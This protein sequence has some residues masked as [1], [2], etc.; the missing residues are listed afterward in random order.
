[1][2][3]YCFSDTHCRHIGLNIPDVDVAIFAGDESD[4]SDPIRN[5]VETLNFFE[6]YK[7][8]DIPIKIYVP[9]NHSIAHSKGLV[10]NDQI[11]D[12]GIIPLVHEAAEIEGIKVFGSPYTPAFNP[13]V[14][15]YNV[16]RNKLD[17]YWSQI[18]DEAEL[19]ITHGPGKGF[20][21]LTDCMETNKII[22]VG[23][24]SLSNRMS[25]LKSLKLHVSGH[26]HDNSSRTARFNNSG[27]YIGSDGKVRVNASCVTD[28]QQGL[29]SHGYIIEVDSNK[30]IVSAKSN[31]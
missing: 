30:Q 6:W 20:G 18:P 17:R 10:T 24:K 25:E 11:R 27:I 19:V 31:L 9:G 29:S 8:L 15:A 22:Q 16:K 28:G 4:S 14:W 12:W 1:M 2:R 7:H 26:L 5:L 21:D 13:Q 23:C 3:I